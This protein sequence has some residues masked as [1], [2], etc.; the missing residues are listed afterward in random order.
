MFSIKT[1][2]VFSIALYKS[3]SG[4]RIEEISSLLDT[5]SNQVRSKIKQL[6]LKDCQIFFNLRVRREIGRLDEELTF[7]EYVKEKSRIIN[8]SHEKYFG[9]RLNYTYAEVLEF[10]ERFVLK[11]IKKNEIYFMTFVDCELPVYINEYQAKD[12]NKILNKLKN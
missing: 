3:K 7:K 5:N 1:N 11:K 2:V 6:N 10:L 9:K 4:L 8:E 12:K